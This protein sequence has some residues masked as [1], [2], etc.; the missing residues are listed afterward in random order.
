MLNLM[1]LRNSL[2]RYSPAT[3]ERARLAGKTVWRDIRL[4][5]HLVCKVQE[6]L[7]RTMPE[8][9][10]DYYLT[11]A[12]HGHYELK[13]NGPV[14]GSTRFVLI[15][16]DSLSSLAEAAVENECAMCLREGDEI[17]KC[18]IRKAMIEV[19]PPSEIEDTRWRKCEYRDLP[20]K[21]FRDEE[22]TL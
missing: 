13:M 19:A 2:A 12:Q 18:G 7:I 11:Y 8:R 22:V 1:V 3:K 10:N 4:M 17:G 14:R 5:M 9:R 20:G 6:A 15:S 16:T 21:L